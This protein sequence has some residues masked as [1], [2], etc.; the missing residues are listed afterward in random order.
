MFGEDGA[1][2]LAGKQ[3]STGRRVLRQPSEVIRSAPDATRDHG[4]DAL[5]HW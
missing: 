3:R 4:G 2:S 5:A 1:C